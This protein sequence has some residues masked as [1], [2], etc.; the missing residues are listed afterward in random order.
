MALFT[1]QAIAVV[2]NDL[3]RSTTALNPLG[4]RAF[5]ENGN[6][7]TYVKAGAAIA[8]KDAVKIAGSALGYDDVRPTAAD[9]EV[10]FGVATA[11][12][13]SAAYGFVQ[14]RGR[15]TCKVIVATA[16]ASSL[17]PG[18]TAGTLKLSVTASLNS[19][20]A[21]ALVTGVAAGS[22]ILLI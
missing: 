2:G 11:A 5:D 20:P 10:L 17:V 19:K 8:A 22:A 7:Y 14:T 18:A 3:T 9:D 13:D 4:V 12:F 1:G 16:A 6:E 21:T 15:V